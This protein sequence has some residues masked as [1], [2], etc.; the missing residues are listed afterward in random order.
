M[1][2]ADHQAAHYEISS[3][4]CYLI[5]VRH[6]YP[7]LQ[8]TQPMLLPHCERPNFAPILITGKI[9]VM[10]LVGQGAR[11]SAFG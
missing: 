9:I 1:R 7:I 10:Y 5:R 8:Y 3:S 2:S 4:P 11:G 6:N